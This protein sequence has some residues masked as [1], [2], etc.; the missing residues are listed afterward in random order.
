MRRSQEM[1]CGLGQGTSLQVRAIPGDG[2]SSEQ[3]VANNTRHLEEYVPGLGVDGLSVV[4]EL[5]LCQTAKF[6]KTVFFINY[7]SLQT[8]GWGFNSVVAITR[9]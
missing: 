2:F 8:L 3:S 6:H 4:T 5:E 9:P 7:V 1:E